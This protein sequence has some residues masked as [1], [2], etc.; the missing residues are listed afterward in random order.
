[1]GHPFNS[2]IALA[3]SASVAISTKANPLGR[4]VYRSVIILTDSTVPTC[5]NSD[6]SST[7]L[8]SKGRFPTYRL[9]DLVVP[10]CL[11]VPQRKNPQRL[12]KPLRALK[13]IKNY[14]ETFGA[15][16]V[17]IEVIT[18]TVNKR[19]SRPTE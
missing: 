11:K 5:S 18:T 3:A 9:L 6:R 4:P 2:W 19:P 16:L 1:M 14:R 8:A 7:P 10:P 13:A 12:A 17:N 15:P